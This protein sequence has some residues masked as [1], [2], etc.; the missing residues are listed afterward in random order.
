MNM[1]AEEFLNIGK[2]NISKLPTF[3]KQYGDYDTLKKIILE[4]Q[5]L[6]N[7]NFIKSFMLGSLGYEHYKQSAFYELP[8]KELIYMI[9]FFL[10][11]FNISVC[12]ELYSG[13]ALL[14]KM[15]QLQ[16]A[17]EITKKIIWKC[18]DDNSCQETYNNTIF[19][20]NVDKKCFISYTEKNNLNNEAYIFC[21][22]DK[23]IK[24]Y[25]DNF[26]K[27]VNPSIIFLIDN[28]DRNTFNKGYI[29]T[30]YTKINLNLKQI[31]YCDV[32][33]FFDNYSISS[34][35]VYIR[36]NILNNNEINISKPN[37][38]KL[39]YNFMDNNYSNVFAKERNLFFTQKIDSTSNEIIKIM[40]VDNYNVPKEFYNID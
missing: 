28:I 17:D 34:L 20:I 7:K 4:C 32:V 9:I 8:T 19:G 24:K 30:N 36:N 25:I 2:Y 5:E 13:V 35:S 16:S 21:W 15:L 26:C 40:S 39:F 6:S 29:K 3:L 18:S 10:N 27:D 37:I 22:P 14:T 12:H 38:T 1:L 33:S 23:N 11:Y 31:C